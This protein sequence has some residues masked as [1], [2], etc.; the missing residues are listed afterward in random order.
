M[1]YLINNAD[2]KIQPEFYSY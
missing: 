2:F 1:E